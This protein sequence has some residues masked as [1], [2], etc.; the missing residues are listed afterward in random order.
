MDAKI[1][2]GASDGVQ[3]VGGLTP[4]VVTSVHVL[5]LQVTWKGGKGVKPKSF[6]AQARGKLDTYISK[7]LPSNGVPFQLPDV[8][9]IMGCVVG[10]LWVV[11]AYG[12]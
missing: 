12:V 8:D 6:V 9:L 10:L 7:T 4:R 5:R 3:D 1:C 11:R 2:K